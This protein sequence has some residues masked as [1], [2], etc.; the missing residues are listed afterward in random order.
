[1]TIRSVMSRRPSTCR[2]SA[3]R[4]RA[5]W[6]LVALF[7]S[8]PLLALVAGCNREPSLDEIRALQDQGRYAETV[9]PLRHRLEGQPDDPETHYLYG[10]AL[11]RTG[12]ARVAIWSLRKAAET[13]AWKVPAT[14]ELASAQSRS[15]HWDAAIAAA[16]AGIE[17]EPE[18][19][20]A[21]ILR[22]EA[23]LNEGGKPELAIEDFDF[24]LDEVPTHRAALISRA[25]ALLL[26]GRVDEAAENIDEL[27]A[28]L[29]GDPAD[30]AGAAGLCTAQAV[31]RQ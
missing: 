2:M 12:D 8:T 9:E 13:E 27:E 18:N 28:L 29:S 25:S 4:L 22:G 10:T 21:R 15:A 26:A 11:S 24:V 14:L 5:R 16:S 30:T 23:Y 17:A 7:A 20:P 1:M 6:L 3:L 19:L 31:L